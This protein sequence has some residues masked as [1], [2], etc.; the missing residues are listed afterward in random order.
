MKKFGCSS[1]QDLVKSKMKDVVELKRGAN[2]VRIC[3]IP[4]TKEIG[5]VMNMVDADKR[6]EQRK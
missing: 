1:T 6:E 4:T 2:G 5:N 3:A